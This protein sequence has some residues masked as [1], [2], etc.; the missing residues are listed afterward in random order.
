LTEQ[1]AD[2]CW[3]SRYCGGAFDFGDE[4]DFRRGIDLFSQL[5]GKRYSRAR[6]CTPAF[7][8]NEFGLRSMLYRLQ[9]KFDV[10][11]LC[12]EEVTAAGWDRRD[13]T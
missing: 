12:E 10:R 3:R 7:A 13:Y 4:D 11:A 9:A 6:P 8:R 5:V 1:W 2:W